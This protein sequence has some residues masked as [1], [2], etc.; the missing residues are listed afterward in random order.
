MATLSPS[1]GFRPAG[2]LSLVSLQLAAAS[3]PA[4]VYS[5]TASGVTTKANGSLVATMATDGSL[6]TTGGLSLAK[7]L[8]VTGAASVTGQT[9][10][11][12][13]SASGPAQLN[14]ATTIAATLTQTGAGNAVSLAGPLSVANTI[15]QT[16]AGAVTLAGPAFLSG[17]TQI[18]STLAQTGASSAVSIAGPTTLANT[19]TVSGAF[20]TSLGGTLLVSGSSTFSGV[21]T[22]AAALTQTGASNPV[23]LAGTL[24]SGVHTV[25]AVDAN[26]NSLL[27]LAA[28]PTTNSLVIGQTFA[29]NNAS[30]FKYVGGTTPKTQL[31]TV[32]GSAFSVDNAGNAVVLGTTTCT[33]P[34]ILSNSSSFT[35]NYPELANRPWLAV[36]NGSSA[37]L[38]TKMYMASGTTTSGAVT[39]YPTTTGASGGTPLFTTLLNVQCSCV[40]NTTTA[41]AVAYTGVRSASTASIIINCVASTGIGNAPAAVPNGTVI[42]VLVTGT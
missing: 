4:W 14:G 42:Y 9:S 12:G 29:T 8:A 30:Y 27:A 34:L 31:G 38:L 20:S 13:V 39:F 18:A 3:V 1:D 41:N 15:T 2:Q 5:A 23:S 24:S 36:Y 6:T 37:Q 28:A 19:L 17:A 32:G 33:Q 21:T 26:S 7:T 22:V 35:G 10:L 16:G 11:A 40:V 25:T